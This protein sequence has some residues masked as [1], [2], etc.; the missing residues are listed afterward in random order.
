M[1]RHSDLRLPGNDTSQGVLS[2]FGSDGVATADLWF[3][4]VVVP[5]APFGGSDAR[6]VRGPGRAQSGSHSVDP[7]HGDWDCGS[8]A[9]A[10]V[11]FDR[12][13]G[14]A[15]GVWGPIGTGLRRGWR[16]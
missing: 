6:R 7:A 16:V 4:W 11:C 10:F 1:V 12:L 5:G 3:V 8:G 9:D 13:A 14:T 2:G 15:C